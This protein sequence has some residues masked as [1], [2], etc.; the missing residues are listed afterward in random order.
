MFSLGA[1]VKT[2]Q[3]GPEGFEFTK[4][5]SLENYLGVQFVDYNKGND[6]EMKQPFLVGQ[7]IEVMSFETQMTNSKPM[8]ATKPLLHRD[9]DGEPKLCQ[10]NYRSVIG[11]MNYLQQS[12]RPDI[13]FAVYQCARFCSNP[14]CSHIR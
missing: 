8:P 9:L 5:G 2:L 3:S 13:S 4:D 6:F 1:F 7:I 14:M 11:M 12:T 10:W